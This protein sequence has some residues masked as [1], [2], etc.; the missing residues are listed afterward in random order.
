MNAIAIELTEISKTFLADD[1][2]TSAVDGVSLT[3]QT[4]EFLAITGP[5]GCGKS[6]LLSIL[7]LLETPDRG[8]VRILGEDCT[9]KNENEL[10]LFRRGRVSFVFQSFNLI[11]DMSIVENTEIGLKYRGVK[12]G[13]RR[14][15][16]LDMLD[17]V[18]LA[19]RAK[20][21]P[22]QLSGGQQQ[23][24]ALAR[25]LASD[26]QLILADE[27]TGNLDSKSG[28]AVMDLLG[29]LPARGKTL[30]VVTHSLE[31]AS[32]ATRRIAMLDGRLEVGNDS[33]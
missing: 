6:T 23:R 17:W 33:V 13:L 32:R 25:A 8:N 12:P 1:V 31:L 10:A 19:H 15:I 14:R 2:Q 24:A 4:G 3:V 26:A 5:S 16:A 29:S 20:H 22:G 21:R 30:I 27:P 7:G 28:E 18:G 9:A 11:D